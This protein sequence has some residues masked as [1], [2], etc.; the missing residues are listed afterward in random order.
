MANKYIWITTQ[1]EFFHK[2]EHAPEE[3][4]FLRNLHRHLL[5]LKVSIEVEKN[6]REIEFF[7]FKKFIEDMVVCMS[8][9]DE[10]YSCEMFSDD[11]YDFIKSKYPGRDVKIEV[12]EDGENGSETFYPKSIDLYT[13]ND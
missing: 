8:Y 10:N 13:T 9:D 11:L 3:V 5:K 1:Q 6:D 4:A 7:M 12:S 2:Y